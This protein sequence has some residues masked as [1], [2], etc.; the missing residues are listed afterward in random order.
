MSDNKP[1]FVRYNANSEPC[2]TLNGPCVCGAWHDE[3]EWAF[4]EFLRKNNKE[5]DAWP[6][7]IKNSAL[8][9]V[10]RSSDE[11]G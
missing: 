9:L 8:H 5:V 11:E 2:D 4:L 10:P 7:H 3:K 1:P 6:C